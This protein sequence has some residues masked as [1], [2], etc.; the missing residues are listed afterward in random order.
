MYLYMGRESAKSDNTDL[1]EVM[2]TNRYSWTMIRK[3]D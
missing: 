3:S 2:D 1:T